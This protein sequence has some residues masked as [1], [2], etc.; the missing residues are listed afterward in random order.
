[1]VPF[2]VPSSLPPSQGVLR[3]HSQRD[4]HPYVEEQIQDEKCPQNCTSKCLEI[5]FRLA[6]SIRQILLIADKTDYQPGDTGI[7]YAAFSKV[8]HSKNTIMQA[9]KK[10]SLQKADSWNIVSDTCSRSGSS[11]FL[12]Y[13][14]FPALRRFFMTAQFFSLWLASFWEIQYLLWMGSWCF[15]SEAS[16]PSPGWIHLAQ[17]A[18]GTD[19]HHCWCFRR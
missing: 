8:D 19:H 4:C 9:P 7:Y 16:L 18:C 1:M 15:F 14:L 3:L 2:R 6:S 12:H 11:F 5:P 10:W 13:T 17:K